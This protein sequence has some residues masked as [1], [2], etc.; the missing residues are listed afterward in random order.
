MVNRLWKHHFGEGLVKSLDNF[1]TTGAPPTHPKLLDWLAVYFTDHDWSVKQMHRL[2][3]TSSVYRQSS[4]VTDEHLRLDPDDALLSR[5]P[6]RRMEGEV[7]RDALLSVAGK[8]NERPF[9]PPDPLSANAAGLVTVQADGQG[10]WRRSIYSLKR[11]TQPVTM[12]QNFDVASMDPNCVERRESIVAPQALQLKNSTLVRN[13][14]RSFADRVWNVAGADEKRQ[15]EV[16]YWLAAGRPPTDLEVSAAGNGLSKL[17]AAW[18]SVAAGT[19]HELLATTHLWIRESAPDNVCEN[20]L[21]SVWS[22]AAADGARRIGV[23]EFD[24]SQLA[25]MPIKDAYL[26]L[27]QIDPGA[28]HQFAAVIPSGVTGL[29]WTRFVLE[30]QDRAQNLAALGRLELSADDLHSGNYV[31][32]RSATAGDFQLLQNAI[33]SDGKLAL[34]LTAEEDGKAYRQDWD[35]G[36]HGTTRG[37]TPRLIVIED[38]IDDEAASRKA[39]ENFCHAL[40]NSAA[41]LYID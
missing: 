12:L 36:V 16:A 33:R 39:L 20:D 22:R 27:G 13:L 41:F 28:I 31:R 14:A 40:F 8:L 7:L 11:R 21:I 18:T 2:L 6:L 15:I 37:S 23:L 30:K 29:N 3:M 19:R 4:N 5:M 10:M 35:D 1:G 38:R 17:K 34:A 24:V 9:G 32:S 25:K 26:E